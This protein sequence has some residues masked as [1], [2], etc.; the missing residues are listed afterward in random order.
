MNIRSKGSVFA[1]TLCRRS[2]K[3]EGVEMV[4]EDKQTCKR[5]R[6]HI[7]IRSYVVIILNWQR[8]IFMCVCSRF[9]PF[10]RRISPHFFTENCIQKNNKFIYRTWCMELNKGEGNFHA[11]YKKCWLRNV[12][13]I[14]GG[15][16]VRCTRSFPKSKTLNR[17][18]KKRAD[19]KKVFSFDF[20]RHTPSSP[21]V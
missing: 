13:E 11:G 9:T 16:R 15:K 18:L 19:N 2:N 7:R 21:R 6:E 20:H 10:T 17:I 14:M 5:R 8:N 4:G 3:K 12:A 1:A